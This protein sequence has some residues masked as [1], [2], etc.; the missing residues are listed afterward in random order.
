[1]FSISIQERPFLLLVHKDAQILSEIEIGDGG[2]K[3]IFE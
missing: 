2:R 1:M 3:E